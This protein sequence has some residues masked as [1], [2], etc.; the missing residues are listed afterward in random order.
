MLYQRRLCLRK[1]I[2]KGVT[3]IR[4]PTSTRD[5]YAVEEAHHPFFL[6]SPSCLNLIRLAQAPFHVTRLLTVI[7][8]DDDGNETP[9]ILIFSTLSFT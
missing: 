7:I 5:I 2:I 9:H 3:V 1:V 4:L 6:S 8:A